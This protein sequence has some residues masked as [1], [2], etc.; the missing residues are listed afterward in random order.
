MLNSSGSKT[1]RKM[2]L[3]VEVV[4]TRVS[5]WTRTNSRLL[6][7]LRNKNRRFCVT[8]LLGQGIRAA[9]IVRD[10]G[11]RAAISTLRA[12]CFHSTQRSCVYHQESTVVVFDL[13]LSL[14]FSSRPGGDATLVMLWRTARAVTEL[15][16]L[17]TPHRRP[18]LETES[19]ASLVT[20][21]DPLS[22]AAAACWH[23]TTT[24]PL[25]IRS[26]RSIPARHV[27]TRAGSRALRTLCWVSKG[28]DSE[29]KKK[30]QRYSN[31]QK[32]ANLT[33]LG[34]DIMLQCSFGDALAHPSGLLINLPFFFPFSQISVW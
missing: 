10:D 22:M 26:P 4:K 8:V 3:C 13:S 28:P 7:E 27:T 6:R 9:I 31:A 34:V 24:R 18:A 16:K 20:G 5:E 33:L 21:T 25:A 2:C 23:S 14:F 32:D 19:P 15:T 11:T 30:K 17:A 29:H 12:W 1:S